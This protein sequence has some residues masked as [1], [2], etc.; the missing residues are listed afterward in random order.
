MRFVLAKL[1]LLLVLFVVGCN[2]SD[3]SAAKGAPAQEI[4]AFIK[5]KNIPDKA[6]LSYKQYTVI[7]FKSDTEIGF[8]LDDSG[9]AKFHSK[10]WSY[11]KDGNP[12]YFRVDF[13][14]DDKYYG[15]YIDNE[16]VLEKASYY[17]IG[18]KTYAME[19]GKKAFL[20]P[21]Q[22]EIVFYD[23]EHQVVPWH[24]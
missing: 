17:K 20:V 9:E 6:V 21:R 10:N 3:D 2:A 4:Q 5:E 19:S 16:S 22:E 7:F 23:T 11:L 8:Y 12:G 24:K 18:R 15:L 14:Y 1:Q 13:G